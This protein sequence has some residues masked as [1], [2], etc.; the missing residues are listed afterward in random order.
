MKKLFF[1]I[2]TL[3]L[4]FLM[5]G[6]RETVPEHTL[7]FIEGKTLTVSFNDQTLELVG[8][9]CDYTN[10][11]DE[12][13]LPC[14]AINVNA[15]QNGIELTVMVF[16][17]QETEGAVQCDTGVQSGTTARVVWLFEKQDDSTV[18]LEFTD[19][20]KISFDLT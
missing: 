20:Q 10:S 11:S 12:T 3:L 9:F 2:I 16:T 19:G 8:V 1:G 13:C 17:G 7:V 4:S 18:S 5:V 15:Y 14:D 6:C